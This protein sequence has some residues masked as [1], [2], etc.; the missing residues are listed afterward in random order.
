M[1]SFAVVAPTTPARPE[2]TF[3][4][5]VLGSSRQDVYL[6]QQSKACFAWRIPPMFTKESVALQFGMSS[7]FS[8]E[9]GLLYEELVVN[10]KKLVDL[11]GINYDLI[12][13]VAIY[14]L[15]R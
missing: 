14:C 1:R 4:Q 2:W 6:V 3:D 7:L 12:D 11:Q 5:H 8:Q 9:R 13:G 10:E 15:P